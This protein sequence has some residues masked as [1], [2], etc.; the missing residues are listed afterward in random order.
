M[1]VAIDKNSDQYIANKVSLVALIT[2]VLLSAF[3]LLAGI[4]AHSGAMVSDAIHSA[5]DVFTTILVLFGVNVS[6]MQDDDSHQ[7]GHEKIESLVGAFMAVILMGTALGIGWS[8]V[9]N[10]VSCATIK[11][12]GKLA[13]IAAVVSIASQE[14]MYWY[15]RNVGKKINSPALM[16][17]AWHHRS[18]ALSSVGSFVGIGG[19]MLGWTFLDPLVSILICFVIGKVAFDIGK[20]AVDQ[21]VD[22]AADKDMV[23]KIEQAVMEIDG[24]VKIDDLKTRLHSSKLFVDL[25]ISVDGNM[26]TWQTHA[27]AEKVHDNVEATCKNVKHIMVH[28]NP[29]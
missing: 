5:S 27:I 3:K 29:I 1:A 28:V 26:T 2:N 24:V 12:P 8:G 11:V 10:L 23:E 22:R 6:A 15:T 18:D 19:A 25:E 21:L 16:A 14:G 7:Y 13:L 4:I 9:K 20:T 17:D